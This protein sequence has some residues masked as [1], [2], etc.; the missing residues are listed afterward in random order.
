MPGLF[1]DRQLT[2]PSDQYPYGDK[3]A[4]A[5]FDTVLGD[6]NP[7]LM[8]AIDRMV[9]HDAVLNTAL[10]WKHIWNKVSKE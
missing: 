5:P 4:R 2:A 1:R 9:M 3:N 7:E 6:A 8:A 10:F